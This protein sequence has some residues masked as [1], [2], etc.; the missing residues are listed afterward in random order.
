MTSLSSV[1]WRAGSHFL[2]SL[3]YVS[4]T[5]EDCPNLVQ[6]ALSKGRKHF[7]FSFNSSGGMV[8]CPVVCLPFLHSGRVNS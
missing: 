8:T 1:D 2:L 6:L 7:G 5:D 3:V 4:L